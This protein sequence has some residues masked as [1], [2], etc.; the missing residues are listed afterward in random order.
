M[1]SEGNDGE[2]LTAQLF[3]GPRQQVVEDVEAP[4]LL[5]LTDGPRLF[6]QVWSRWGQG[7]ARRANGTCDVKCPYP[8]LSPPSV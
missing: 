1:D 4:L 5:G 7:R 8:K 3:A 6:Q 2:A